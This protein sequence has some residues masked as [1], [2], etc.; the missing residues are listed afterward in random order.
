ML[1]YS[2]LL[3]ALPQRLGQ[4]RHLPHA[5]GLALV[6]PLAHLPGAKIRLSLSGKKGR[7]LIAPQVAQVG[8]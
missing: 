4:V 5:G 3:Q 8:Q 6:H 7:Q 1:T 2:L